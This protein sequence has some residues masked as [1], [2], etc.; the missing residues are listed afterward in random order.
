MGHL[1]THVLD[2]MHGCP[3]A[4]MRVQLQRIDGDT[5]TTIKSLTLNAD[6]RNDGGPL[7]NAETM[8]VGRYR[9]VFSVAEYFRGRDVRLPEPAFLDE[10]PLDFGI[11]DAAGHYHVPL[12]VS[13]WSYSTY[14][15]S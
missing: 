11:A 10:V 2:T 12:L 8:A 6:G 3:A 9:L 4:G 14:R 13:P 15:G 1:S 7:L 5:V